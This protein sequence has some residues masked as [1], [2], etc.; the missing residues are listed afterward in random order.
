MSIWGK[1]YIS[2]IRYPFSSIQNIS[3]YPEDVF[4]IDNVKLF[5]LGSIK[6]KTIFYCEYGFVSFF[7]VI[8][9]LLCSCPCCSNFV[10][11]VLETLP[12]R[13]GV[14]VG[15]CGV[16]GAGRAASPRVWGQVYLREKKSCHRGKSHTQP[17]FLIWFLF[18]WS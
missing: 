10:P 9:L 8:T 5:I 7:L 17:L 6:G 4:M 1:F 16:S 13:A 12:G 2:L 15:H 18:I 14:R 3:R 11:G